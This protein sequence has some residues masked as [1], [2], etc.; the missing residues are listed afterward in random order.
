MSR[1]LF[2]NLVAACSAA[3]LWGLAGLPWWALAV[4]VGTALLVRLLAPLLPRVLS[5]H[6]VRAGVLAGAG[7][8]ALE[9]SAWGW[10][11]LTA[12]ALVLG[13]AT[14]RFGGRRRA[15]LL[16][17]AA[18]VFGLAGGAGLFVEEVAADRARAA[19]WAQTSDRN[20]AQLLPGSPARAV[21]ALVE[22]VAANDPMACRMFAPPAAEQLAAALGAADCPAA[23][24]AL[25]AEVVDPE[26]YGSPDSVA[27]RQRL[28]ADAESGT[29]D[30]CSMTWAGLDRVLGGPRVA[31]PPPGPQLGVLELHRELGQGYRVTGYV[32]CP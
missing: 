9:L 3:L 1:G 25:H 5:G 4:A 10:L 12:A 32:P 24:S 16:L 27:V 13:A 23:L 28:A 20:R 22:A 8:A 2:V 11:V 15:P 29:G 26:A 30:G 14:G 6:P 17:V 31:A 19:E 21:R 18:V 7:T